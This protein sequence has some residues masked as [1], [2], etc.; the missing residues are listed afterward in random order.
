MWRD[1]QAALK[2]NFLVGRGQVLPNLL[3]LTLFDEDFACFIMLPVDASVDKLF[4][5]VLLLKDE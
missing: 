4:H 5:V 1:N 3:V 2:V